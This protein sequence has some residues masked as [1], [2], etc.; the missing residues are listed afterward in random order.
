MFFFEPGRIYPA[1]S[2]SSYFA[3]R[4]AFCVT[5]LSNTKYTPQYSLTLRR[6]PIEAHLLFVFTSLHITVSLV[7]ADTS[8]YY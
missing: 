1:P 3:M 4:I 8:D 7:T 6:P 2:L 5:S